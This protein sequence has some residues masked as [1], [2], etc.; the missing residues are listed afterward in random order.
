M[1][2]GTKRKQ[3]KVQVT[4]A[5]QIFRTY[6]V[7]LEIDEAEA[8]ENRQTFEEWF[9]DLEDPNCIQDEVHD[10]D[11]SFTCVHCQA[12]VEVGSYVNLSAYCDDCEKKLAETKEG[13]HQGAGI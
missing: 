5:E 2:P 1:M 12:E 3:M 11:F 13:I 9:C 6:E 8:P 4:I 7:D 10:R